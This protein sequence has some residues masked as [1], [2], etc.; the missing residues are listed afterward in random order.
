MQIPAGEANIEVMQEVLICRRIKLKRTC[1][2]AEF[3]FDSGMD[4][5]LVSSVA[6][7]LLHELCTYLLRSRNQP[8]LPMTLILQPFPGLLS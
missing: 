2:G 1:Q 5:S 4:Y 7:F 6:R 3:I 8:Q